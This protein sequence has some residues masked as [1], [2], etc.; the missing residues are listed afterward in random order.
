[1]CLKLKYERYI[2]LPIIWSYKNTW[3][4][5]IH[6]DIIDTSCVSL[7]VQRK[8]YTHIYSIVWGT[9]GSNGAT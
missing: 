1:M 6:F 3:E 8:T 7:C 2:L 5:V 4:Q 9:I